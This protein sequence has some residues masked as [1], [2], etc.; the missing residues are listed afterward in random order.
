[1][2]LFWAQGPGASEPETAVPSEVAL[3]GGLD[4]EVA[5]LQAEA[6]ATAVTDPSIDDECPRLASL[7][8]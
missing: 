3:D 6:Q 5:D 8:D 2:R 4:P 1:M 7:I